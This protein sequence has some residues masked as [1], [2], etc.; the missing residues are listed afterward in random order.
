MTIYY[1]SIAAARIDLNDPAATILDSLV[2]N[3]GPVLS[4]AHVTLEAFGKKNASNPHHYR[5]AANPT[6]NNYVSQVNGQDWA[7][8][9]PLITAQLTAE[10]TR[11]TAQIQ[12][13]RAAK[14]L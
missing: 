6:Q 4:R 13:A 3:V 12:A 10:E 2:C 11:L 1:N 8:I 7:T 14:R 5:G 9:G